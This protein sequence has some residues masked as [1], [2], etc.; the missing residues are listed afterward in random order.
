[1]KKKKIFY[2]YFG[3]YQIASLFHM[4]IYMGASIVG[5]QDRPSLIVE[6]S[7]PPPTAPQIAQNKNILAHI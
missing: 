2:S 4:N 6:P 7:P 1:M 5:K 3:S